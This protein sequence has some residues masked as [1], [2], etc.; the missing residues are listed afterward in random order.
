M[1]TRARLGWTDHRPDPAA[2]AKA[3][4]CSREACELLLASPFIDLH[5]DL[6]VPVRVY[7]YDPSVRHAGAELP[8]RLWGHT[9]YPR[10]REAGF[11][12]IV[13]DIATN[14]FRPPANRLATTLANVAAAKARIAAWPDDLAVV[15]TRAEHDAAQA[16]GKLALFLALQGGNAVL[17]DP[18]V[19]DGPLGDELH[20][21]TLMHLTNSGLGGTNSPHGFGK[22]ITDAGREFVRR[23]NA[24]KILVDLAHSSKP[25]FWG[26]LEAHATDVPPIVSHTGVEGVHPHWRNIDDAQIRAIADRGG[27]VGVM[28]QS[29]FLEGVA[30]FARGKRAKIVDHLEHVIKVVGD[31]FAAIGTDYDGAITPPADLA[32]VTHHPLVVQDM[33]D[34]GWSADRI[35]GILGENYLR[36]VSAVRP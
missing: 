26:A 29:G 10:L 25:T 31:G 33:L 28:Y 17:A 20:R 7:G 35:R 2:W 22:S 5:L 32:D 16:A 8:P 6:E 23:C 21:I 3:L 14:P 15:R 4:G 30:L 18:G 24:R 19:L 34:R 12:A 27:V 36:V 1:S 9:D 11:T 13:Y